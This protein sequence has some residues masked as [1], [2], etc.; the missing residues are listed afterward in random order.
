[1]FRAL[2]HESSTPLGTLV[3]LSRTWF[4]FC[5]QMVS[6]PCQLI[7]SFTEGMCAGEVGKVI[8][9]CSRVGESGVG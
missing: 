6:E 1:M 5:V 7:L 4:Q 9:L 8:A 3:P 2:G